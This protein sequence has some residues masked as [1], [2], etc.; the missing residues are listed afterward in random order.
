MWTEFARQSWK[1]N[2]GIPDS[3]FTPRALQRER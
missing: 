2:T 3:A 1:I